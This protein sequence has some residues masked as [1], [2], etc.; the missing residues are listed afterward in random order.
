MRGALVRLCARH[1]PGYL[2]IGPFQDIDVPPADFLGVVNIFKFFSE[3][4]LP[5]LGVG[6]G[7]KIGRHF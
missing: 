6:D 7:A 1:L 5:A 2:A 4:D 3:V